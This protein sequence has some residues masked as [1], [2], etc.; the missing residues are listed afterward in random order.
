MRLCFMLPLAVLATVLLSGCEKDPEQHR[1]TDDQ[2]AWQPYRVNE[3]LRFGHA[4]DSQV[5]TYRITEVK[6]EQEKQYMGLNFLPFPSRDVFGQHITVTVQR[7]DTV[8]QPRTV[9]D[10]GLFYSSLDGGMVLEANAEWEGIISA[11][12]PIGFINAGLPIDTVRF[13]D[14]ELLSTAAFGPTAYSQV[15]HVAFRYPTNGPIQ[16]HLYYARQKGVVAFEE[17]GSLWYRLP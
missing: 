12:L 13:P 2:L 10:L 5:R 3:E 1:L 14:A 9:L 6:D 7:T 16:G 15:I 17:K 4:K 11:S 8:A